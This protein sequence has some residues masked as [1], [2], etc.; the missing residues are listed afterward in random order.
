M[1]CSRRPT[2]RL[3]SLS[4]V[5][6]WP[7]AIDRTDQMPGTLTLK[8]RNLCVG[9]NSQPLS[10]RKIIGSHPRPWDLPASRQPHSQM[11]PFYQRPSSTGPA[12]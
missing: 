1:T 9:L 10:P 5:A 3:T 4:V 11:G 2:E 6:K 8:T 7:K 12:A